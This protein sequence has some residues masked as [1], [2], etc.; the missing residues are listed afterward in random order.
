[1]ESREKGWATTR[2][3]EQRHSSN[4][5]PGGSVNQNLEKRS[6]LAG[7]YGQNA[8]LKRDEHAD[9]RDK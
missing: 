4:R 2:E 7:L 5:L 9:T 6:A 8:G 1:M 3:Y